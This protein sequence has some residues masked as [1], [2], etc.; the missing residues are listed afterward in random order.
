MHTISGFYDPEVGYRAAKIRLFLLMLG[1][2]VA[3]TKIVRLRYSAD[4]RPGIFS[5]LEF[6][7]IGACLKLEQ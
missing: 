3:Q 1:N 2:E 5:S 4:T 7:S 6:K